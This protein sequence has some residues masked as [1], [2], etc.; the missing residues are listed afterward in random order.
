[1]KANND[2]LTNEHKNEPRSAQQS[3]FSTFSDCCKI[4]F[5]TKTELNQMWVKD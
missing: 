4:T 2:N 3:P 1:M 5:M